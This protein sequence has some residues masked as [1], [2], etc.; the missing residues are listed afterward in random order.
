M[1]SDTTVLKHYLAPLQPYLSVEDVTELVINRPGELGIETS[2]GWTWLD[3]P[4]LSDAALRPLAIAAAAAT[5]QDVSA[6]TPICSTVLPSG[7][8]CQLVL[9]PAAEHISI[10][11]RKPSARVLGMEDF[12]RAGLFADVKI[13]ADA[14]TPD[15]LDLLALRDAGDWTTFF[16]HAVI[17]RKNILI[18]GATGSGKT[19]FAKGLIDLIPRSERLITLEEAR[20]LVAPHRNIVHPALRQGRARLGA[21]GSKGAFGERASHAPRSHPLAGA[22]G[23]DGLFLSSQRQ[24]RTSW[25]HHH[26]PR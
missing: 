22:A 14:L 3:A 9:P 23:R 18:S 17:K 16:E 2:Q 6:E 4:D 11:L 26:H 13:A 21:G 20:E 5:H 1:S 24:L 8:R 10:T 15:D 12:Q 25:V 19:T 7:E